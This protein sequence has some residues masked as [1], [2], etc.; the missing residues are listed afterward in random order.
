MLSIQ[1]SRDH[2]YKKNDMK[3]PQSSILNKKDDFENETQ[4]QRNIKI[5]TVVGYGWKSSR[6]L[7]MMLFVPEMNGIRNH[8]FDIQKSIKWTLKRGAGR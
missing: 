5:F 2:V 3:V 1:R 7:K 6:E 4:L 8:C